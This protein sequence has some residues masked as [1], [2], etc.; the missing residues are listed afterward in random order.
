MI[1]RLQRKRIDLLVLL[2]A[3]CPMVSERLAAEEQ[4]IPTATMQEIYGELETPYKYGTL[5]TP[6]DDEYYDCPNVFRH[7]DKWLMVF[8]RFTK[9]VGYETLLAES[10][11]L[12][13][14]S[15]KGTILGFRDEGWDRW[16]ADG[17]IALM[18][19]T[20]GGSY[21][22][23]RHDGKYWLSYF[24]GDKQGYETDPLSLGIAWTGTP[25]VPPSWHRLES[26]PVMRP[27]D[28]DSREFERKTLYKSH[29]FRDEQQSLGAP[30]VMF[31]NAKQEGDWIERIG[32][33]VSDDMRSWR[34]HGDGPVIDNHKGISGDPQIIRMKDLW[35]MVYF[36]AGWKPG[37]FDTF[38]V[39]RDLVHWTKWEGED[40]VK[41]S[42]PWDTPFAHKPW[43]VKHEGVVYHFYCSVGK[44]VRTIALATSRDVTKP[45]STP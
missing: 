6:S 44:K 37:A 45:T 8:V 35:V 39:S 15:I 42:E 10:D 26:N 43:L 19:P 28:E 40:L 22:L 20:W 23:D 24:G 32:I 33:A 1:S 2:M 29:I 12:L 4:E 5:L 21:K 3:L 38:A 11:N 30:F 14:W 31:Y 41:P 36:G 18:D 7:D 16:Q 34:R 13:D 25:E 27:D 17:S 9:G